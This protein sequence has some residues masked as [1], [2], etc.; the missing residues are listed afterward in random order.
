MKFTK[1]TLAASLAL[2]ATLGSVGQATAG[3]YAESGLAV[4]S[5]II[6]FNPTTPGTN[7]VITSFDFAT[8][9]TA[10][11]VNPTV[12][13]ASIVGCT[14]DLTTP[15]TDC[16][17]G[18]ALGDPVLYA[19]VAGNTSLWDGTSEAAV[20]VPTYTNLG[21]QALDSIAF[22]GP[23]GDGSTVNYALADVI[24]DSASLVGA[25]NGNVHTTDTRQI[26]ET[27]ISSADQGA[28]NV[29]LGSTTTFTY[30]LEVGDTGDLTIAF[31]ADPSLLVQIDD[32]TA[33]TAGLLANM[34]VTWSL[35]GTGVDLV[36]APS[37][38]NDGTNPCGSLSG[39]AGGTGCTNEV[40]SE[41]LNQ[42]ITTEFA[43]FSENEYSRFGTDQS[44]Q[45]YSVTLTGLA[46]GNYQ[47]VLSAITNVQVTRAQAVPEPATLSLL[48]MGLA[49]CGIGALRRKARKA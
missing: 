12:G 46:P 42:E 7:P 29:T 17:G 47:L 8:Q 35:E 38:L 4:D 6:S 13:D 31:N 41:N 1:T 37:A 19:G 2:A 21:S 48:G 36:W 14:G 28:A 24:I 22:E 20:G 49:M 9:A 40:V 11:T 30:I 44:F 15:Q 43:S 26:A 39:T 5:L 16:G 10:N 32:S 23:T 34:D 27:E 18:T 33:S 45:P 25:A 3:I